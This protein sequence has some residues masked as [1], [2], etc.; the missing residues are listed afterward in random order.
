MLEDVCS[1]YL[2]FV[3]VLLPILLRHV[4]HERQILLDLLDLLQLLNLLT[5]LII[6]CAKIFALC[7]APEVGLFENIPEILLLFG[8]LVL[9]GPLSELGDSQV[10]ML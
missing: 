2:C 3:G 6:L 10:V 5:T 9:A 7:F 1:P 8:L 4:V